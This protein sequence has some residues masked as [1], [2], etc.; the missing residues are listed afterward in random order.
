MSLAGSTRAIMPCQLAGFGRGERSSLISTCL[1]ASLATCRSAAVVRVAPALTAH[2]LTAAA[3]AA[4][5]AGWLQQR[6]QELA[7]D[8]SHLVGPLLCVLLR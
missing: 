8:S 5:V 7:V 3:A 4:A 2:P 1:S 6:V